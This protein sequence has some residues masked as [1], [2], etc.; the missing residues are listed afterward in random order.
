VKYR[1]NMR[2]ENQRGVSRC[3][4]CERESVSRSERSKAGVV[5]LE[6]TTTPSRRYPWECFKHPQRGPGQSHCHQIR[7]DTIV[8]I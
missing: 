5:I 7:Y 1:E 3:L 2:K 6:G 4:N 8:C